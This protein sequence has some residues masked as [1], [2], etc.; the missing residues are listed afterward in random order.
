MPLKCQLSSFKIIN[1]NASNNITSNNLDLIIGTFDIVHC[2]HKK[3]FDCVKG[4]K[5]NVLLIVNSPNKE[6]HINNLVNRI[7]NIVKLKPNIIYLFDVSQSNL[8]YIDFV[9]KIL[10]K[11]YPQ[12]IIV[13]KNFKYGKD[14]KG[15][16]K[17]LTN[18]FNVKIIEIEKQYH[19]SDVKKKIETGKIDQ[20]NNNILFPIEYQLQIIKGKQLGRKLGFPTLNSI[21]IDKN[22]IFVNNGVYA[23]KS[24]FNHKWYKSATYVIHNKNR[25][26]VESYLINKKLPYN[27][28]G[29]YY[30][31]KFIKK[32]DNIHQVKSLGNLKNLINGYKI[33]VVNYFSSLF[34]K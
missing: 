16:I 17:Y 27:I 1:L 22:L 19:T 30:K 7:S 8:S 6:K 31:L 21:I 34:T 15:S 26:L 29:N 12:R 4:K 28:Y 5:F 2:G 32:V 24:Y 18:F 3:L 25:I 23:T 9:N 20:I 33:K 10:L 14:A 13:G 11:I